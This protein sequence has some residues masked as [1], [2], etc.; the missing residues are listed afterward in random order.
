MERHPGQ[1]E[2]WKGDVATE[3]GEPVGGNGTWSGAQ[4]DVH[5]GL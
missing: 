2:L 5:Q 4:S 1:H 3:A